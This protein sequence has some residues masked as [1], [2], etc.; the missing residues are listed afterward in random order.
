MTLEE[1]EKMFEDDDIEWGVVINEYQT[2]EK[3]Q[4][5]TDTKKHDK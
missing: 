2:R 1:F 5:S 4:S 3:G